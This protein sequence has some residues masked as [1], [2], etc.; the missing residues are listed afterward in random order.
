[1]ETFIDRKTS[2]RSASPGAIIVRCCCCRL[3]LDACLFSPLLLSVFGL[4]L[5][6]SSV[7][8]WLFSQRLSLSRFI[9]VA[10]SFLSLFFRGKWHFLLV[11]LSAFFCSSSRP[12]S[13]AASKATEAAG[14]GEDEAT[15]AAVGRSVGV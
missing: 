1:M 13:A 11:L 3:I 2:W 8:T 10:S 12:S 5:Q 9:R 14:A 7:R 15:A 6:F 4:H